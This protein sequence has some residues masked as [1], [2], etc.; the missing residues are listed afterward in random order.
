MSVDTDATEDDLVWVR[1]TLAN[2]RPDEI[3]MGYH[4]RYC[5]T[6]HSDVE[7][8]DS[9]CGSFPRG[10]CSGHYRD[11]PAGGDVCGGRA[12]WGRLVTPFF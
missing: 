1:T 7:Y 4:W 6:V 12:F 5:E 8:G 10:V 2:Y 11:I 3:A 9:Q